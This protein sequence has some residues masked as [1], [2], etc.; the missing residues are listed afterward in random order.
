MTGMGINQDHQIIR[1]TRILDEGV[2]AALMAYGTT[3][4]SPKL[5]SGSTMMTS[6]TC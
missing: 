6:Y 4:C 2:L 3:Y 1:K 5:P